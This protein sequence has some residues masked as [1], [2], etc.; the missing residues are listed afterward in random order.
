[1]TF[2]KFNKV[3][4]ASI[5][6]IMIGYCSIGYSQEADIESDFSY[7]QDDYISVSIPNDVT[8][9]DGN[10]HKKLR[11][12]IHGQ[13]EKAHELKAKADAKIEAVKQRARL[14][15]TAGAKRAAA[16]AI[17]K[18]E[19]RLKFALLEI[20]KN[21]QQA[22]QRAQNIRDDM[23]L[24]VKRAA[25]IDAQRDA[26]RDAIRDTR[27]KR[28]EIRDSTRDEIQTIRLVAREIGTQEAR[29]VARE[30]TQDL[31]ETAR[32]EFRVITIDARQNVRDAT[33]G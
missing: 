24:N 14:A 2:K 22:I 28:Q 33:S 26:R 32:T 23:D 18:I 29:I 20:R 10:I 3:I 1:M 31:R 13:K 21:I 8:D 11:R 30:V 12:Y 19:N 17:K 9:N 25:L 4:S 5:F 27:E 15:G 6:S 16:Q 7:N